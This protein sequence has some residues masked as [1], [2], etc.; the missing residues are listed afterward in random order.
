MSKQA[1][2]KLL[3]ALLAARTS[4]AA[5]TLDALGALQDGPPSEVQ[6]LEA[7][8]QLRFRT[9][10][11]DCTA[12]LGEP[13]FSTVSPRPLSTPSGSQALALAYWQAGSDTLYLTLEHRSPYAPIAVKLG[14]VSAQ[15][16]KDPQ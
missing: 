8:F 5:Q 12:I 14:C 11:R 6:E 7:L 4:D 16:V 3:E 10:L 15:R 2:L 13:Q 1:L 9:Y